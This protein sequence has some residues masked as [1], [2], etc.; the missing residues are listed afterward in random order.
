M[1]LEEERQ[2]MLDSY[3]K[4]LRRLVAPENLE[5]VETI[6]AN[7]WMDGRIIQ[8]AKTSDE[9]GVANREFD[10]AVDLVDAI[11]QIAELNN[12]QRWTES[13]EVHLVDTI[14]PEGE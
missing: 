12:R 14:P 7:A 1:S 10:E 5:I 3:H 9:I 8:L 2:A 11:P 4:D 6:V 13:I